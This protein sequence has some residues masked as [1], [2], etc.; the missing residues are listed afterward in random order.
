MS[1]SELPDEQLS[2]LQVAQ[3]EELPHT[4]RPPQGRQRAQVRQILL[5]RS[6][7][8]GDRLRREVPAQL[9]PCRD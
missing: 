8:L 2:G 3:V 4:Q 1:V 5:K 7:P 9:L 6:A